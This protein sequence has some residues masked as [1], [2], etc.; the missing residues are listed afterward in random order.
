VRVGG[1]DRRDA[2]PG[3]PDALDDPGQGLQGL[4]AVA[5]GVVQEEHTAGLQPLEGAG[6]DGVGAGLLEVAGVRG[7]HDARHAPGGEALLH[8]RVGATEG[9]ADAGDPQARDRLEDVVG[10]VD[11]LGE[12]LVVERPQVLV[13]PGVVGDGVALGDDAAHQVREPLRLPAEH[14][15]GGLHAVLGQ[16][17]EDGRRVAGVGAVVEGERHHRLALGRGRQRRLVDVGGPP[18]VTRGRA[19][20]AGRPG[21]EQAGRDR[22]CGGDGARRD[23]HEGAP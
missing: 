3:G 11:L 21:P 6:H 8:P 18:P 9:R 23:A 22:E 12:G 17:V 1:A 14:E 15:E 10:A 16:Q 19:G 20:D 5:A 7:P 2:V 4:V 13:V